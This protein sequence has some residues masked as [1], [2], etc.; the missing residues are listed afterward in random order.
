MVEETGKQEKED[1]LVPLGTVD[2]K[3]G[4]Q[5]TNE[6]AVGGAPTDVEQQRLEQEQKKQLLAGARASIAQFMEQDEKHKN[7]RAFSG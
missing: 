7:V 5:K 1:R 6:L 3:T 2:E 4:E